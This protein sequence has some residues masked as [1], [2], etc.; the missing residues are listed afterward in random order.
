MTSYLCLVELVTEEEGK[1]E[2][3]ENK[4]FELENLVIR[5]RSKKD[6]S[7]QMQELF[8]LRA[9]LDCISSMVFTITLTSLSLTL[10]LSA[11]VCCDPW[12]LS[13]QR[14]STYIH[15][16]ELSSLNS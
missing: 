16:Y 2:R 7:K 5:V 8:F 3:F 12:G 10:I 4:L 1:Q 6:F 13:A 14:L 15:V 9:R 11:T